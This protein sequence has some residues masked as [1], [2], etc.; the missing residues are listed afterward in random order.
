[1]QINLQKHI[2]LFTILIILLFNSCSFNKLFLQ[3]TKIPATTKKAT[4]KAEKD[5]LTVYFSGET[6]QP[7][8]IKNGTDTVVQ[9][10]TIESVLFN[11]ADGKKLN[12]WLLKPKNISATITLLHLHGNG[13]CLLSQYQAIA[14]LVEKGFQ[15]FMFDYSGF[16]FSEGKPTRVHVLADALTALD[17]IKTR[18][19]VNNTKL[20][21]YGQSLGGHLSAVVAAK[22]E[23]DISG[24]V[25]EGAFSSHKDIG[26]HMVPFFGKLF[27]KQGYSAI[28]S[29]KNFHKPLLVIHSTEDQ[30]IPFY[31]GKK[32]FDNANQPK[33]FY[34]VKKCHI[35]A[36]IFFTEE[37]AD[38]I[39]KML[40]EK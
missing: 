24:L 20:V 26:G 19:D 16:G 32:I 25:I 34:E 9:N 7:S 21:I 35:C 18:Q 12:G 6:H 13:G 4:L 23:N 10:F 3:P 29:I 39:K 33:E 11:N 36:P 38:K 17:Y 27:V 5:T 1:M 30:T 37:I 15:V 2:S 28:K 40:N 22:R 14:P 31:M 8:F